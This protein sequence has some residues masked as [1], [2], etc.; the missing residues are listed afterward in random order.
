MERGPGRPADVVHRPTVPSGT[1]AAVAT[2]TRPMLRRLGACR[3]CPSLGL[4]ALAPPAW[5]HVEI[6]PA[7]AVAGS[8]ATLT[9][10]V[11]YE[12]AATTGL[13]VQLPDGASVTEVPDKAGWT[14]SVDDAANTVTWSGGSAT[15]D[16]TFSVVVAAPDHAGCGAV[17][18]HR[19]DHRGRGRLDR[20]RRRPRARTGNPAPRLTLV[21]DP[22]AT[23]TTTTDATTTTAE[24]TTT[25]ERAAGHDARGRRARRRQH[26]GGAVAHRLGDRRARWRSASAARSSS[27][28]RSRGR[29]GAPTPTRR[30]G[31]TAAGGHAAE[32]RGQATALVATAAAD[33]ADGS[34]PL[35]AAGEALDDPVLPLPGLEHGLA[36]ARAPSLPSDRTNVVSGFTS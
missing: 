21:A 13:E 8:T 12:G 16:E 32:R 22:N 7:E 34:R 27:A 23:T 1:R 2:T 20:A 29:R 35:E 31:P 5:A 10:S 24:A 25:T 18:R 9:F 26:V 11:E 3:R 17:P 15:A 30:V 19:A 36:L 28:G 4:V 14:S 6:E 33:G